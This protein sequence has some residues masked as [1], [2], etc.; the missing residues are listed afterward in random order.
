MTPDLE[1]IRAALQCG[2]PGCA[3][4]TPRGHV[5][6]PG[7]SDEVPSFSVT[8]GNGKIL[9]RCHAGCS[10]VRVIDALKAR[11]LWP[12]PNGDRPQGVNFRIVATY[13]YQDPSGTL[14][15]QVV[16]RDPKDFRQR[17]PDPRPP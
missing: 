11:N 15:F 7:H 13:D 6:C 9:V 14:I 4:G 8:H 5:H 1:T 2:E 3:C 17:R 10:Q 16:R 12:S